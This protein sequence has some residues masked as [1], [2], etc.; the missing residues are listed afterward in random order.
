MQIPAERPKTRWEKFAQEQN[1]RDKK[2][3]RMIWDDAIKDWV[4]RW[5]AGSA[6]HSKQKAEE[7]VIEMKPGEGMV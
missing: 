5:G 6:K 1:I 7:A 2:R 3:S 4:P